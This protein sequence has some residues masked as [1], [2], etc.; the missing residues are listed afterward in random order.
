AWARGARRGGSPA[1]G[2]GLGGDPGRGDPAAPA[3]IGLGE[4]EVAVRPGGDPADL[5]ALREARGELGDDAR[6]G[7]AADLA[8]LLA[9]P[10][11]SVGT[12][13]DQVG[14]AAGRDA[15]GELGDDPRGG[16]P[17]GLIRL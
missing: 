4:P 2:G 5:T 8:G 16:D 17:A 6:R 13:G 7:D 1:V 3:K 14:L 15:R 9:E 12:G 11:V 10:E